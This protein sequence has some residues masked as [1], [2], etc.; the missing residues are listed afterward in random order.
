MEKDPKVWLT[1]MSKFTYDCLGTMS[2]GC[3]EKAQKASGVKPEKLQ[4]LIEQNTKTDSDGS[5]RYSLLDED[6]KAIVETNPIH[7]PSLYINGFP[8]KVK[9]LFES[10]TKQGPS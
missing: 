9:V 4:K 2:I 1:Y 3:S 7:Y 8:Y 10:L 6:L 5:K